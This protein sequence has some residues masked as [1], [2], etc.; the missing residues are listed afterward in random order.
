MALLREYVRDLPVCPATPAQFIN[1]LA[2][3]L[4]ARSG[5]FLLQA[6]ENV[7]K[8]L[9]WPER[10]SKIHMPESGISSVRFGTAAAREPSGD[11]D[12]RNRP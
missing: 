6:V 12:A 10:A 1:Q 2:A 3:G 8:S 9:D 4:K 5:R 11:Q 7:L